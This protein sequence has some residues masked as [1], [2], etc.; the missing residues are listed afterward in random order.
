MASKPPKKARN[1]LERMPTRKLASI[2]RRN[3]LKKLGEENPDW[4]PDKPSHK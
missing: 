2:V 1:P 3:L 4:K